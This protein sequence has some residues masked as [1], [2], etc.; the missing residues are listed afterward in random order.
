LEGYPT[1]KNQYHYSGQKLCSMQNMEEDPL[2]EQ[3]DSLTQTHLQEKG[4]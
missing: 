3:A 2:R 1:L 4:R